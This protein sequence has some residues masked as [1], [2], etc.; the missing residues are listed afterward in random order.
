MRRVAEDQ[1]S[2]QGESWLSD[3]EKLVFRTA[4]EINQET[5]LRMAA[6]RQPHVD[7]GQSV[8]LYFTANEDEREISRIHDIAFK[9]P[10]I[11]SLYYVQSQ[12]KAQKH[13][14]DKHICESC[15]G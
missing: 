10:W 3:H 4:F 9:D 15:Q 7:Q 13:Q 2:I 1:G 12:N 14:V 6:Q 5:I 8:N 11:H